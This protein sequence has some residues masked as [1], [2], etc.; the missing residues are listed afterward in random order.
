MQDYILMMSLVQASGIITYNAYYMIILSYEDNN[1]KKCTL[2]M[3]YMYISAQKEKH[4]F[5]TSA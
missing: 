5:N 3:I 2:Y 1:L 4:S